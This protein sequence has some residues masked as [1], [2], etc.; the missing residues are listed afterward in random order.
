MLKEKLQNI[1]LAVKEVRRLRKECCDTKGDF[2]CTNVVYAESSVG[3][4]FFDYGFDVSVPMFCSFYDAHKY[5]DNTECPNHNWNKNYI[6][7]IKQL[8]IAK[9]LR[10]QAILDLFRAKRK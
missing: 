8:R 1:S 5:C 9:Y 6:D 3:D 7:L 4:L 10:N 2:L